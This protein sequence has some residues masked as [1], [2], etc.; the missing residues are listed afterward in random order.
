[1]VS[2][3]WCDKFENLNAK[4]SKPLNCLVNNIGWSLDVTKLRGL[5][6]GNFWKVECM[7]LYFLN[8]LVNGKGGSW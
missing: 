2:G 1:L 7:V 6:C 4:Y 8:C 5:W 3:L